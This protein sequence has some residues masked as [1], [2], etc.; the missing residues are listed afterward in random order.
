MK[1]TILKIKN[2]FKY[3][4]F[5]IALYS[6]LIIIFLMI[7]S[8]IF[9]STQDI[10]NYAYALSCS[11][12]IG[13]ILVLLFIIVMEIIF[14]ILLIFINKNKEYLANKDYLTIL[15]CNLIG[16]KKYSLNFLRFRT[17]V[18]ILKEEN[19][20]YKIII[21][22]H[23]D[24]INNVFLDIK[25][26]AI[27]IFG[28]GKKHGIPAR[29]ERVFYYCEL[30]QSPKKIYI[31]QMHCNHDGGHSLEHYFKCPGEYSDTYR[32]TGEINDFIKN[33]KYIPFLKQLNKE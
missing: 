14:K 20:P 5:K 23:E 18:K 19:I 29:K 15:I 21:T 28:H 33:K 26:K 10:I 24:D 27:F 3:E 32:L 9:L 6:L 11:L 7:L 25:T 1:N 2:Y 30:E 13:L 8:F 31:A 22:K 12:W 16:W 17:L 4:L